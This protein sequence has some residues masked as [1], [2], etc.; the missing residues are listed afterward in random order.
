MSEFH[1]WNSEHAQEP[2]FLTSKK[3]AKMGINKKGIEK[4]TVAGA[5]LLI[6]VIILLALPALKPVSAWTWD[7]ST[8]EFRITLT[9][10]TCS[11]TGDRWLEP[12]ESSSNSLQDCRK[13]VNGATK[14]C[15]PLGFNCEQQGGA[16]SCYANATFTCFD[17]TTQSA[18]SGY[19]E[20]VAENSVYRST[21]KYCGSWEQATS[22][23]PGVDCIKQV[24]NCRCA[25]SNASTCSS[26]YALNLNCS[27][28]TGGLIGA[29]TFSDAGSTG[30]EEDIMLLKWGGAWTGNAAERPSDCSDGSKQVPCR[31]T[32]KLGFFTAQ[33]AIAAILVIAIIYIAYSLANRQKTSRKRKFKK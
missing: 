19:A 4:R 18:C 11:T 29:C 16:W 8:V 2:K 27:D 21:G 24:T 13:T 23:T 25:W 15:C 5:F 17:Y 3:E 1:S 9:E 32:L 14:T 26:S 22:T 6:A 7:E 20:S 31:P 10:T 30:C 28:G 33:N 12:D